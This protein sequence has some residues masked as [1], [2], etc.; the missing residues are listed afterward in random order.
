MED[1]KSKYQGNSNSI[2][3][4]EEL[5]VSNML[6]IEAIIRVLERKDIATADEILEEVKQLKIEM[7][8][9]IKKNS[10]EN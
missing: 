5:I 1:D 2:V 6:Q 10:R 4:N 8:E 9:R 3:T 7:E